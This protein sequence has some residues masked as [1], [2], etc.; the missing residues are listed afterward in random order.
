MR[1]QAI[2]KMDA[3]IQALKFEVI[4]WE[5]KDEVMALDQDMIDGVL[6]FKKKEL[7]ILTYI[8]NNL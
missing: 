3:M 8:K 7:N 1:Q 2:E 6:R 4:T 5:E